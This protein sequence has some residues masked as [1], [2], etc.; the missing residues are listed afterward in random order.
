MASDGR[1][2]CFVTGGS[3]RRSLPALHNDLLLPVVGF[4]P[5]WGSTERTRAENRKQEVEISVWKGF[6]MPCSEP[7]KKKKGIFSFSESTTKYCFTAH[8]LNQ[9]SYLSG[10]QISNLN[11]LHLSIQF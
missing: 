4:N 1:R 11:A 6:Y 9:F 3:G 5:T 8:F 7:E 10:N 2:V